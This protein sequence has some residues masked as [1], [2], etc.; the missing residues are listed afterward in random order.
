M[1]TPKCVFRGSIV[2][3]YD[4]DLRIIA[5]DTGY[6]LTP[7]VEEGEVTGKSFVFERKEILFLENTWAVMNPDWRYLVV[8]M[9]KQTSVRFHF[10]ERGHLR[11]LFQRMKRTKSLRRR[12]FL[13]SHFDKKAEL[14]YSYRTALTEVRRASIV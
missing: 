8:S 10:D 2:F 13:R 1:T 4:K 3:Y 9:G 6:I 11:K 5:D 12:M 7:L 14:S